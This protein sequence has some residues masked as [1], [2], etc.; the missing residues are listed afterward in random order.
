[1][2]RPM[3]RAAALSVSCFIALAPLFAF[4]QSRPASRPL[5]TPT[6]QPTSQ[7]TTRFSHTSPTHPP[8]N[9][10]P[11]EVLELIDRRELADKYDPAQADRYFEIHK[12]LEMYFQT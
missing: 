11:R 10:M 4:A 6:S 5:T 12:L 3:H 7:P 1:M 2:L 9:S 8:P